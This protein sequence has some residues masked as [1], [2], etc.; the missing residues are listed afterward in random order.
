MSRNFFKIWLLVGCCSGF[1]AHAQTTVPAQDE[2]A[3]RIGIEKARIQKTEEFDAMERGCYQR[4]AV[5]DCITEVNAQRR[6][7]TSELKRQEEAIRSA[8][9]MQ[10]G[11][12]QLHLSEQKIRDY[13][14]RNAELDSSNPERLENEKHP[15]QQTKAQQHQAKGAER[16]P[17][18][19]RVPTITAPEATVLRQRET[20]YAQKIEEAKRRKAER[21][22]R[23]ADR[24]KTIQGL[25]TPP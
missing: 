10:R 11:V 8:E 21:D 13:E 17:S 12:D 19:P 6:Q 22:K 23:M 18:I 16:V 20:A 7:V 5:N 3:L 9:R 4:F 2:S 14:Q 24:N 15:L 25:P 1:L